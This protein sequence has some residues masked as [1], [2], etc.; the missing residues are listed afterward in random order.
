MAKKMRITRSRSLAL[1]IAMQHIEEI[2]TEKVIPAGIEISVTDCG[3]LPIYIH[4]LGKI[5]VLS[6]KKELGFCSA[7]HLVKDLNDNWIP[8]FVDAQINMNGKHG[9]D[10]KIKMSSA[11]FIDGRKIFDK[12]PTEEEWKVIENLWI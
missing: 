10:V 9:P 5:K 3:E 2:L 7:V 6:S 4:I 11:K 1:F 12:E 8:T